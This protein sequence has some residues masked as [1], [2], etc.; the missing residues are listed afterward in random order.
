MTR[1]HIS[2]DPI[3]TAPLRTRLLHD[4]AGAFAAFEGWVRDHNEGRPVEGLRYEAYAALAETET[5]PMGRPTADVEE[6][7]D[8]AD[9]KSELKLVFEVEA[10]PE[11]ELP[12][13]E[14][15]TVEVAIPVV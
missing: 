4:R 1:F 6:W 3:D 2:A 13:F 11:F 8:A 9:P 7:L 14:G 15:T 10:R 12:A 5:R